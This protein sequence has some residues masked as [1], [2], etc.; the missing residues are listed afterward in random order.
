MSARRKSQPTRPLRSPRA[1]PGERGTLAGHFADGTDVVSRATRVWLPTRVPQGRV[2]HNGT[3]SQRSKMGQGKPLLLSLRYTSYRGVPS[4]QLLILISTVPS[5]VLGLRFR[6]TS[7]NCR[8]QHEPG[9]IASC[10]S[11][12]CSCLQGCSSVGTCRDAGMADWMHDHINFAHH[13]LKLW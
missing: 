8:G 1:S 13:S 3:E 12:V 9:W 5:R 10:D 4:C 11:P 2:L 7:T 6:A